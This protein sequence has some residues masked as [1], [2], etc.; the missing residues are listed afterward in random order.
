MSESEKSDIKSKVEK[1]INTSGYPVELFVS[2]ILNDNNHSTWH[3]RYF[4][5]LEEEKARSV[6]IVVPGFNFDMDDLENKVNFS[7]ELIIECKK[8]LKTAWV[9]FETKSVV[10]HNYLGQ[11]FDYENGI[12]GPQTF[13]SNLWKFDDKL[14]FHYAPKGKISH[15]NIA[16]SFHSV[17]IGDNSLEDSTKQLKTKDMIFEAVNQVV[18]YIVYDIY[19]RIGRLRKSFTSNGISP[20]FDWYFPIIVYDGPMYNGYLK[21]DKIELEERDHVILETHFT[22]PYASEPQ[23]FLID[24]VKKNY[25]EKLLPI[26]NED[27]LSAV[28]HVRKNEKKILKYAKNLKIPTSD[29]PDS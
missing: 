29:H 5:D 11:S 17:K 4:F 19:K 3:S 15:A 10:Q 13:G 12:Y 6:D 18:K 8:S 21:N 26:L 23:T 20:F 28:K 2:K 24:V 22:V 1:A 25:F 27:H 7:S 14:S 16:Q 9:F